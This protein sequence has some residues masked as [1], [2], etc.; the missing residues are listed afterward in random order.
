MIY[1]ALSPYYTLAVIG[2][3]LEKTNVCFSAE[4]HD[5]CDKKCFFKKKHSNAPTNSMYSLENQRG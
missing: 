4:H 5:Q 1:G 3:D 2:Q